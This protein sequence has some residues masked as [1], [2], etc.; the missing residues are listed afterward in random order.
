MANQTQR[1]K[2]QLSLTASNR[3]FHGP[4]IGSGAS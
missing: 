4:A 2:P 1:S 3:F